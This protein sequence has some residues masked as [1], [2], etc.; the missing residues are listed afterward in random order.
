MNHNISELLQ[1][2]MRTLTTE[3]RQLESQILLAK[4]LG[5]DRTF[6]FSHP[7]E[8]VTR[9]LEA[10]FRS[11]IER[12]LAGEPCAYIIETREFWSLPL[13][14]TP[15]TLIPRPET[16][17]LVEIILERTSEEALSLLDLG[18]GSGAIALALGSER[19]KWTILA[20]DISH[21]ALEIA[22]KNAAALNLMNI[23]FQ[24]SNWFQEISDQIFDVIVSNPP[25]IAHQDPHLVEG[26]VRFEP[27]SALVSGATGLEA[28]QLL[29]K[30]ALSYLKKGGIFCVEHGN[31]QGAAVREILVHYGYQNVTTEL[32]LAGHER[33]TFGF[34][35]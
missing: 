21:A 4:V 19:P 10:Q 30:S 35:L 2:A 1:W 8:M 31:T 12:R 29:A 5:R 13:R 9:E 22:R 25:Y 24:Y 16:E 11:L 17:R 6:I 34:Y 3:Q 33:V 27:R 32:D 14:V 20:T 18:T 7:E 15:A 26:D 28:I 23:Q